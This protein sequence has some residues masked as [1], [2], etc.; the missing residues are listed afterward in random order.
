[1]DAL[2]V[3]G[4]PAGSAC[5]IEL[6]RA[7]MDVA[8]IEA[9]RYETFRVGETLPPAARPLLERLNVWERVA[10][11]SLQRAPGI[12]SVWGRETPYSND[13]VFNPFG[14]GW[15]LDRARFDQLMAEA[16]SAAGAT[17]VAGRVGA[18]THEQGWSVEAT[19]DAGTIKISAK[20][21]IDAAGRPGWPGRQAHPRRVHDRLV[22]FAGD[23]DNSHAE[24]DSDRRTLIEAVSNGWWYCAPV[25]GK[26]V[27][28]VFFTDSDLAAAGRRGSARRLK[29]LITLAPAHMAERLCNCRLARAATFPANGSIAER[30]CGEDWIAIGDAACT[31]DPLSS[32]GVMHALESA[33]AAAW[34]I[35]Q[36]G[37][38]RGRAMRDYRCRSERSFN[39][40]LKAYTYHYAQESR[41]PAAEFWRRRRFTSIAAAKNLH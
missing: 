10:H 40:Y 25:P 38:D 18:A 14:P 7:G 1:M 9:S 4:G 3:G 37:T 17:I 30:V 2:V 34:A 23:F 19:T 36:S 35:L 41:W 22:A 33:L 28:A 12:V 11:D 26:R 16:A 31:F 32:Q 15:H 20:F 8:L 21:L 24:F 6:A 5:A 29:D 27:V 13:F 39:N